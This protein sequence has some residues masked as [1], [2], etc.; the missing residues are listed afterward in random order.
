MA[1]GSRHGNHANGRARIRTRAPAPSPIPS[2]HSRVAARARRIRPC[3]RLEP[4]PCRLRTSGRRALEVPARGTERRRGGAAVTCSPG[5]VTP[6]AWTRESPPPSTAPTID[7]KRGTTVPLFRAYDN[8]S[9][10]Y[11]SMGSPGIRP[12]RLYR[13]TE[14]TEHP[15]VLCIYSR[16]CFT[17]YP[18]YN[19]GEILFDNYR[20]VYMYIYM[21]VQ[22]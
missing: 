8:V 10:S 18:I 21:Y 22:F 6:M 4:R 14:D 19:R 13:F 3:R 20:N 15:H 12:I 11:L 17:R 9:V 2:P 5:T 1:V 16:A 7:Q